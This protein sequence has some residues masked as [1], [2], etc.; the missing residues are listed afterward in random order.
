LIHYGKTVQLQAVGTA[1]C[2]DRRSERGANRPE[3]HHHE[4]KPCRGRE[5]SA[6]LYCDVVHAQRKPLNSGLLRRDFIL[7]CDEYRRA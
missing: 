6:A 2:V 7:A 5:E 4:H 1:T 3:A